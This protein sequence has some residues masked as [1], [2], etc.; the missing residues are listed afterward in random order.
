MIQVLTSDVIGVVKDQETFNLVNMSII[1]D[2]ILISVN[3]E[4][5]DM[6]Q[7]NRPTFNYTNEPIIINMDKD[8]IK[9]LSTLEVKFNNRIL[10]IYKLYI[11]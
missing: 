3:Q 1:N 5:T 8:S 10:E 11:K 7:M 9:K 4:I 2:E 6:V